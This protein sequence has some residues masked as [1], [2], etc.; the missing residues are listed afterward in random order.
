[1]A[2]LPELTLALRA[3]SE[4][5]AKLAGLDEDYT[6]ATSNRDTMNSRMDRNGY[7]SPLMVLGDVLKNSR[8]RQQM[9][10]L[11]PQREAARAAIGENEN[12]LGLFQAKAAQDAAGEDATMA[13]RTVHV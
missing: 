6:R 7:V 10:E 4:G 3:G 8:G 11:K 9:R 5:K 2:S 13:E 1:M 12:A